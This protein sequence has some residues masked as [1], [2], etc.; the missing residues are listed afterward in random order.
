MID[1]ATGATAG[2]VDPDNGGIDEEYGLIAV[3][4]GPKGEEVEIPL[5]EIEVGRKDPNRRLLSD[6]SYWFHNWR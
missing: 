1:A 5:H 6:Y 2:L 3:G 4:H